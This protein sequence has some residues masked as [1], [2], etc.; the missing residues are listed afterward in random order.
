[1]S[2]Y[3]PP[4]VIALLAATVYWVTVS[5]DFVLDDVV[6]I[7]SNNTVSDHSIGPAQ[8]FQFPI[9]PGNIYRPVLMLSYKATHQLFEFNPLPYHLF[10]VALHALN[11]VFIY[12]IC[13]RIVI[14]APF[15]FVA[16]LLFAVHPIHVEAVANISGR[17]ETLCHFWGLIATILIIDA[18]KHSGLVQVRQYFFA[19]LSLLLALFTKESGFT[20]FLLIPF[21]LFL[22]QVSLKEITLKC[23]APFITSLSIYLGFRINV[24]GGIFAIGYS[25]DPLDNPL[26]NATILER[27]YNA[28]YI[29]GFGFYKSIAP[30]KLSP[31][32]SLK[33]MDILPPFENLSESIAV[34]SVTFAIISTL[35][36]LPRRNLFSFVGGWILCTTLVTSNLF[37]ISG[38]IF[39]ERHLYLSSLAACVLFARILEILQNKL[40]RVGLTC[41][42]LLCYS[43]KTFTESIHWRNHQT[44]F[45]AQIHKAPNSA[46]SSFNF[47]MFLYNKG[48]PRS[49][50]P[51][52]KKSIEIYPQYVPG[53]LWLARIKKRVEQKDQALQYLEKAYQ[54]DPR[55]IEVNLDLARFYLEIGLNEKAEPHLSYIEKESLFTFDKNLAKAVR[56][57]YDKRKKSAAKLL[58]QL[59]QENP[60][61]FTVNEL[62]KLEKNNGAALGN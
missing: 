48:F 27:I 29:L 7:L 54:I 23:L 17:S 50:V 36:L 46:K 25:V 4:L 44:F 47:G 13:R 24:L 20:Y 55:S 57:F 6:H 1:M 37:F 39:G 26:V 5:F 58:A 40:L 10:N 62:L 28:I 59:Y 18:S 11:C 45:T 32:Y 12:I 53:Y 35:L 15:A 8:L 31:D 2:R 33:E 14:T 16:S 49:A 30:I 34:A 51:F 43:A 41:L 61:N 42:F 21:I 22:N 52:L 3:L 19:S 60:N 38:T 9:F 56:L